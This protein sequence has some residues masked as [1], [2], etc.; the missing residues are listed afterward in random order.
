MKNALIILLMGLAILEGHGQTSEKQHIFSQS[1]TIYL[2]SRY[3][4]MARFT[5]S[6]DEVDIADSVA[7][8]R[9]KE[10]MKD[11]LWAA[12]RSDYKSY[13]RQY[14]GYINGQNHKILF[15]ISFCRPVETWTKYLVQAL[16]GGSCFFE[17]KVN[18]DTKYTF[19][20]Y[21]NAPK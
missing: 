2:D 14:V 17:I 15:I 4:R 7:E 13:Y 1:D 5:P 9:V 16:G 21:V 3:D 18:L 10:Y 12:A 6:V 11:Y 8:I 19:D 20:F